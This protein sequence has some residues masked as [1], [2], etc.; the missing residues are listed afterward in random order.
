MNSATRILLLFALAL[1]FA[2]L[3]VLR[4]RRSYDR[5]RSL[6]IFSSPAIAAMLLAMLLQLSPSFLPSLRAALATFAIL[7]LYGIVPF[8][9]WVR[10]ELLLNCPI[11]SA[12]RLLLLSSLPLFVTA[13]RLCSGRSGL[14]LMIFCAFH[15]IFC[16]LCAACGEYKKGQKG[17]LFLAGGALYPFALYLRRPTIFLFAIFLQLLL[18]LGH[19]GREVEP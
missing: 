2:P 18:L 13:E 7:L 16:S 6:R 17:Y 4:G 11:W 14:L 5:R 1:A 12:A 8:D 3:A 15:G 10:W 9:G 19:R